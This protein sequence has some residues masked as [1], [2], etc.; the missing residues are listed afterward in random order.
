MTEKKYKRLG[1]ILIEKGIITELDLKK[2]LEI[3][4]ETKKPIGQVLVELG[5]CTWEQLT[6]AL[7]EQYNV[8]FYSKIPEIDSSLRNKF[9]KELMEE[10]RFLPVKEDEKKIT[11]VTDNVYNIPLIK[12]RLKFF[13]NKDV[14]IY[15]IAPDLFEEMKMIFSSSAGLNLEVDNIIYNISEEESEEAIEEEPSH[16]DTPIVR[17]VNNIIEHAIELDASDVHIEPTSRKVIIR[18]RIDGVLKRVTEYPK[19]SH[20]SVITRIKILS[21]LDITERRLPQD[22]KFFIKKEGE[23]YDF[24]V[25]TMPSVHGEKI[26]MRILKVSHSKRRLEDSGYTKYN[27]V[28]IQKL[29]EHPHGIILVTGPTGSGKSTTLVGIINTL[30]HEGVNIITAEDPV[31][32]TIEGITQCQVNPEIGLT[33][34]RYLRAFLRQDPD[35]IMVGEIRDRETAQ[36]A[37]EAS[38]TGHLVLSTLHTNTAVGAI[39]RLINMGIDPSLISASLIGVIGQRLVRKVCKDC[40]VKKV[41]P[42]EYENLAKKLYP[43]KETVQYIGNGCQVCNNTGYKGRTAIAEVLMVDDEI[44]KAINQKASTSELTRVARKNGMRTLFEDGFLKVLSGETTLEE[45]LRIAGGYN[46]EQL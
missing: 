24:R 45:V 31:E 41:L 20:N 1:D 42:E 44:R 16:E 12:R 14:E 22:G 10:L 19:I 39:D 25:S 5:Y 27:F 3:Q 2:A 13:L 33:F 46:A 26:V 21:K 35:I 15:L 18:Y 6:K 17:L 28:R 36:L 9:K 34:A 32:Y 30:N 38:L 11:I 37:V 23:Q 4:R 43:E 8:N 40:A 7:A 29:I